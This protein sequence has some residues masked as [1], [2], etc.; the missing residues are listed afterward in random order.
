MAE[1]KGV[2]KE[3]NFVVVSQNIVY[4]F[5]WPYLSFFFSLPPNV[6][7]NLSEIQKHKN[8]QKNETKQKK[9]KHT[10]IILSKCCEHFPEDSMVHSKSY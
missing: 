7:Y 10:H 9:Q 5:S 1:K 8:H 4:N 2:K 3:Y 6:I